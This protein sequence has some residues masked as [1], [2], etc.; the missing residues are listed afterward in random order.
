MLISPNNNTAD[1]IPTSVCARAHNNSA[2]SL[3][4]RYPVGV[5]P[6]SGNWVEINTCLAFAFAA[7]SSP[8]NV[9][10]T[11]TSSN[12][13]YDFTMFTSAPPLMTISM[14][15]KNSLSLASGIPYAC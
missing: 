1:S 7:S 8:L 3:L 4:R 15:G 12:A 6:G 13:E 5:S 9:P 2:T 11:L 10:P 14:F